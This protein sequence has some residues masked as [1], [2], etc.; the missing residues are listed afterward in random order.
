MNYETA[1]ALKE[2]GFKSVGM[3]SYIGPLRNEGEPTL[4]D[5]IVYAPTLTELIE[6][7]GEGKFLLEKGFETAPSGLD[8]TEHWIAQRGMYKEQGATP[9]EA[10]A[11]LYLS[12]HGKKD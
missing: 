8:V 3:G 2:A 1:L 7:C 11:N 10:A 9:I 12:L 5:E 6:A 4:S